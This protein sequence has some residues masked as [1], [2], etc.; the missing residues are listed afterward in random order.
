MQVEERDLVVRLLAALTERER[1]VVVL[2]YYF[3]L[4]EAQVAHELRVTRGT[5]KSTSSR[6]LAKIREQNSA[7]A[8]G[9]VS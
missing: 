2:R 5:V 4:S 6:A 8:L 1:R 9:G 7:E 3:D